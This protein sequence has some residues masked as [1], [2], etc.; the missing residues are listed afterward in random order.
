M[1]SKFQSVLD[2]DLVSASLICLDE[3]E[4]LVIARSADLRTC[5]R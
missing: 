3:T 5:E 4:M 2:A 1:N